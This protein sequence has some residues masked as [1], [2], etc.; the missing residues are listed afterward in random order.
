[1]GYKQSL[2]QLCLQ[3]LR[4]GEESKPVGEHLLDFVVKVAYVARV[5]KR[6]NRRLLALLL[7]HSS[8]TSKPW[9]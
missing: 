8:I 5:V 3:P 1:M 7:P 9:F 6:S 2:D 4:R